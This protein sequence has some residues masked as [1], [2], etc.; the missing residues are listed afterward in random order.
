MEG[1]SLFL[2][3]D[4]DFYRKILTIAIPITLQSLITFAINVMDTIM[5]GSLGEISLSAVS[6]SGQVFFILTVLCFG[7]SGGGAVLTSQFWGKKD[8][9]SISKTISIIIK[10]GAFFGVL[11]MIL[12]LTIPSTLLGFY[13]NDT[14]VISEGVPYLRLASLVYPFF[15]ILTVT[16]ILFRTVGTIKISVMANCVAFILNVFF[17]WVFI[18]GKLGAPAMGLTGAAVGTIIARTVE[19]SILMVYLFCIDKKIKFTFKDLLSFDRG[20][21]RKYLQ[22]GVNVLISDAILVAGLTSLT[23]ILGRLGPEMIAANSICSVVIQLSTIL[24]SGIGNSGLVIIG[25]TIGAGEKELAL[26]QSKTFL[27]LSIVVGI[28]AA[29]IIML[30]KHF[31]VDFYNVTAETKEIAYGLMNGAS[32]IILFQVPSTVLTKGILR[33]GGDTKFLVFAD[34]TFLW[35][36]SIPLG[37]LAAFVFKFPPALIYICLKFDEIIKAIWCTIRMNGDKWIRDVTLSR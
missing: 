37:I 6:I 3:R 21:F 27:F 32:F 1:V 29:L 20:I 26:K 15:S 22:S 23:M 18:F 17:N 8:R 12:S 19:F 7:I 13:T 10:L 9:E 31:A 24:I 16:A 2:I 36:L 28:I 25:N 30:T 35:V 14:S 11:I 33:G 5:V 4:K 34:V